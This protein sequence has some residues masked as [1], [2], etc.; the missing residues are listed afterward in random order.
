VLSWL[1]V[2]DRLLNR[3]GPPAGALDPL[4]ETVHQNVQAILLVGQHD[5]WVENPPGVEDLRS[6]FAWS[7]R[8]GAFA[9]FEGKQ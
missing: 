5:L 8:T 4:L 9:K 7:Y 2:L 1:G 6:G 3:A